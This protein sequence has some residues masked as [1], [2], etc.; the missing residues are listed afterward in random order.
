MGIIRQERAQLRDGKKE[1]AGLNLY[2]KE[3]V[4]E[5]V[6]EVYEE[7]MQIPRRSKFP[8]LLNS[9]FIKGNLISFVIFI[10]LLIYSIWDIIEAT[11]ERLTLRKKAEPNK[12]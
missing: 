2:P 3:E 7:V 12:V 11:Y 4:F 6:T 8:Q 1:R 9:L 5:R 10:L